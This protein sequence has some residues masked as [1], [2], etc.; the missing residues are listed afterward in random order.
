M[1]WFT[2]LI[3]GIRSS[4]YKKS[5][6]NWFIS[7][8]KVT[9][10]SCICTSNVQG[11]WC[12]VLIFIHCMVESSH[13][14]LTHHP[15]CF[16]KSWLCQFPPRVPFPQFRVSARKLKLPLF[17]FDWG[18]YHMKL[19]C[20]INWQYFQ[21]WILCTCVDHLES[22][23]KWK[24]GTKLIHCEFLNDILAFCVRAT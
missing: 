19:L 18:K 23:S 3:C 2:W 10:R 8:K 9:L 11:K 13:L 6:W 15:A 7:L 14:V 5:W 12:S 4:N 17:I 22:V 24:I 16:G 20:A 1:I 21:V